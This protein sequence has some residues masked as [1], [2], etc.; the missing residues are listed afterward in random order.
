MNSIWSGAVVVFA[1]VAATCAGG[2]TDEKSVS[3]ADA[4]AEEGRNFMS[5]AAGLPRDPARARQHF[6]QAAQKGSGAGLLYLGLLSV[7]GDDGPQN[8]RE[9]C[10]LFG[11]SAGRG[12][13]GGLREYGNCHLHGLGGVERD[14]AGAARLYRQS[15]EHGGI[16]AHAPL[17]TL[18]RH[19]IGV[20]KDPEESAR[21]LRAGAAKGCG[22]CSLALAELQAGGGL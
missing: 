18:Y 2:C 10:A 13:P 4:L 7:S 19:G 11:L 16:L 3:A 5:G 20:K 15:I 14:A 9:G 6:E 8:L 17:A 22:D 21:L 12:H 1:C